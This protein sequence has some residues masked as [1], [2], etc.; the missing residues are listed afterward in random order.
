MR[1]HNEQQK[2]KIDEIPCQEI[3]DPAVLSKNPLV[4]VKMITYNHEPYIVQA[5]EG[6]VKQETEYPFELI[7]G[8]DCSTD[9]TREIVFEYQKK[10]P[11]IIRVITSDKN[12]GVK[13]NGYRTT[14][15]CRGKYLAFC[16]GDDYWHHPDKLQKQVDYMESHPECGLVFAD[17]DVYY[18]RSKKFI[19]SFNSFKGFHSCAN[20]T[21]KEII[22]GGMV[23]F[24]CTAMTR[25]ELYEEV[26]QRDPYL[27]QSEELLLGDMQAWAEITLMSEALYFPETLATYRVISESASRSKNPQKLYQ[28]YK[29]ASEMKLYLCDK[30]KLSEHYR[31][32]AES[33]WCD[34]SLRLA[35]HE[36]NAELAWEVKM[37]KRTFT[38]EE[39]LRYL[40]AKYLVIHYLYRAAVLIPNRF[41]KK[42]IQWP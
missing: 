39:R 26:I 23:K 24:T 31:K 14:N 8:E 13:K 10:Y 16:E 17:C 33:D 38:W 36:R 6:V 7:I 3:S 21:I 41:K 34:H 22:F 9:G 15:T 40:G 28:F 4:S 12:V 35:F 18:D 30:H 19:R 42:D 11:E 1:D 5:I 2:F 25:R 29:S 32:I 20:L 37:R 27:Y